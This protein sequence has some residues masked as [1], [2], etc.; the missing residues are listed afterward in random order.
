MA[1]SLRR[2]KLEE[3]KEH[4]QQ[5]NYRVIFRTSEV[6]TSCIL[7]FLFFWGSAYLFLSNLTHSLAYSVFVAVSYGARMVNITNLQFT[8]NTTSKQ[9][10]L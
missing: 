9:N 2:E 10:L 4:G 6:H 7:K 3:H 8:S 5:Y 1:V